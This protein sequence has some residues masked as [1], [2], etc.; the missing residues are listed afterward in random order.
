[1]GTSLLKRAGKRAVHVF[2]SHLHHDHIEGLRFFPPMYKR[3]WRCSVYGPDSGSYALQ[4]IL[5]RTMEGRFFP[6]ELSELQAKLEIRGLQKNE[7]IV[8][9]GRPQVKIHAR[10]IPAHPKFGVQLYRLESGGRS[11]VY[12]TDV[13]A[14]KG[15]FEEVVDFARGADILIHD[16]QYTDQEYFREEDNRQGWGHSTVRM[17][18]ETAREAGVKQLI[19][20]HHDPS[21][22]DSQIVPLEKLAKSIF[23]KSKAAREGM[24][25]RLAAKTAKP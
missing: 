22:T 18:A 25:L 15:G 1:M 16:S 24:T 21:R 17:A 8:L 19:L 12:A 2:L 20:Y 3:G 11:V 9:P 4:K 14:P 6:V 23:P 13:E 7:T 5:A 10:H